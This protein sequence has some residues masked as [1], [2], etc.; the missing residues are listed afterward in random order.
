MAAFVLR[1]G[2]QKVTKGCRVHYFHIEQYLFSFLTSVDSPFYYFGNQLQIHCISTVNPHSS[3]CY[4][5]FILSYLGISINKEV[6]NISVSSLQT[7]I[8]ARQQGLGLLS[9][10]LNIRSGVSQNTYTFATCFMFQYCAGSP[11]G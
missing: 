8:R 7:I 4:Y 3:W 1:L 11:K 6:P 9:E 2:Q 5:I 10:T